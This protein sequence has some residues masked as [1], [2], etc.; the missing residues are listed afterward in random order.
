MDF[1][2]T[3][4]VVDWAEN[5]GMGFMD[6]DGEKKAVRLGPDPLAWQQEPASFLAGRDLLI[7]GPD[8][9]TIWHLR[10]QMFYAE[11]PFGRLFYYVPIPINVEV[12][13]R[14]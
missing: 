12:K 10:L 2:L 7:K 1:T 5:A 8:G 6:R 14:E 13:E 11:T 3:Q 4:E 9:S